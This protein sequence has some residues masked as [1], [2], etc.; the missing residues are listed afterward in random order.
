[1]SRNEITES[2]LIVCYSKYMIFSGN[3][4]YRNSVIVHCFSIDLDDMTLW[5]KVP[6][7]LKDRE[8]KFDQVGSFLPTG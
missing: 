6:H 1:M 3:K 5:L 4:K 2:L 7:T 8:V